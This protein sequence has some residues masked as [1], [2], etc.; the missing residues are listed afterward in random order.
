MALLQTVIVYCQL[1]LGIANPTSADI[2]TAQAR[3]APTQTTTQY[4]T[5]TSSPIVTQATTSGWD[6]QEGN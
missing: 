6:I 1:V 3:I 2:Q 4:V 5:S